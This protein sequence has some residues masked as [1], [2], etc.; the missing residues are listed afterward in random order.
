MVLSEVERNITK[1]V[2]HRFLNLN[3]SSRR[4]DLARLHRSSQSLSRLRDSGILRNTTENV[5]TG[6]EAYLPTALAFYYCGDPDALRLARESVTIAVR[7]LQNLFDAELDKKQFT[8]RELEAQA[9]KIFELR[10]ERE[11]LRLGLYLARDVGVLAGWS[12]GDAIDPD[13][14]SIAEHIVE[15]R[16]LNKVWDDFIVRS[17]ATYEAPHLHSVPELDPGQS[18]ILIDLED[19][20][21]KGPVADEKRWW[22]TRWWGI[23]ILTVAATLIAS[24]IIWGTT[25]PFE[26]AP[27]PS[28]ASIWIIAGVVADSNTNQSLP[29]AEITIPGRTEKNTTD[30]NGN[31]RIEL[32]RDFPASKTFRVRVTKPGYKTRDE[33]VTVPANDLYVLL[34]KD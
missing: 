9:N 32:F 1:T 21:E 16:D 2:V 17:T 7:A 20:M 31:F 14:F 23:L 27:P 10:P 19:K 28:T 6:E 8:P 12:A 11:V 33:T 13:Y 5:P 15:I 26:K 24:L 22:E 25:H 29:R 34:E 30:D 4:S 3:E 18:A